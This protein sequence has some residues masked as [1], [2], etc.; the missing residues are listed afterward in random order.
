MRN[1]VLHVISE[2][3]L[4]VLTKNDLNEEQRECRDD[5]LSILEEHICDTSAHVRSK[6]FQ[7][8]AKLQQENAIPLKIQTQILEKAVAHLRDK[9]ANVRKSAANC[10]T[11]FLSHNIYA[12]TVS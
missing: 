4:R 12:A 11:T 5:F 10:V 1:S 3:V 9:A 8:W 2:V 7:E 6:V